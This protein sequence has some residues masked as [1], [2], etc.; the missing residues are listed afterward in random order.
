[1]PIMPIMPSMPHARR[2]ELL[3]VEDRPE[4][5]RATHQA[6]SEAQVPVNVRISQDGKTL[7][8]LRQEGNFRDAPRP[9]VV[10]LDLDLQIDDAFDLLSMIKEDEALRDI[11]IAVMGPCSEEV[12]D[13][14]FERFADIFIAKPIDPQQ[15]LMTV[16]WAGG[17]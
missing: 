8:I 16:N 10:L 15:L 5:L 13:A 17:L 14:S 12:I 9:D 4:D 2:L 11:P 3:L 1:M 7:A 6:I